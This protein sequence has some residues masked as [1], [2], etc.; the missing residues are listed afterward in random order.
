MSLI[1]YVLERSN[2]RYR[3]ETWSCD[4][5]CSFSKY[6]P[7]DCEKCLEYVHFPS[8]LPT[9]APRRRYDCH[10]MAD[11]Y[12]CKYSY[13]YTSE[14]IYALKRLRLLHQRNTLNVLSFGCGPCTELFA[15]DCLLSSGEL[16]VGKIN[17]R[18]IDCE[19][20]VWANIHSDIK[21]YTENTSEKITAKFYYRDMC[22]IIK[23]ISDGS[24]LPDLVVFQYV[25]SDMAKNIPA[26][27]IRNFIH[28]FSEFFNTKMEI[29]SCIILN[30]IN[31]GINYGGGREY[32]DQLHGNLA[33]TEMRRGHFRNDNR[34]GAY[35]S[36]G[37]PY[38]DDSDGEFQD[39]RNLFNLGP[40]SFY[41]PYDTC[42]S[43]QMLIAKRV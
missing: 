3:H 1:E 43:A 17:Y 33:G 22:E 35:Y 23:E 15:L 42:A 32:F 26:E 12:V 34:K 29:D 5:T 4:D 11:F 41:S 7:Q 19:K 31:L 16:S 37:Y 24:W 28:I 27:N 2:F 13:R 30:D 6:C 9:G 18:G 21:N 25:F 20:N 38:G 10:H 40:W 14:I 39:N 36:Y 8:H